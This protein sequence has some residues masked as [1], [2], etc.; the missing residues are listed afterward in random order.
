MK[1]P[2][3][4][5]GGIIGWHSLSANA[6]KA[7]WHPVDPSTPHSFHLIPSAEQG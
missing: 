1:H 7:A 3:V 2:I 5:D 6:K 4:F